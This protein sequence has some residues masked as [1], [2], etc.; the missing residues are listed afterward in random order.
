[1]A[2]RVD[3]D[4]AVHKLRVGGLAAFP[5]E[6]L[7]SLSCRPDDLAAVRALRT[8]K[9]RPDD[10]PLALGF[11][12]WRDAWAYAHWTPGAR[13]LAEAFLPGPLSLVLRAADDDTDHLAPGLG[14]LSVRIPDHPTAQAVLRGI[15]PIVM[16]S[17]NR[18]GEADA[19]SADDVD[20]QLAGVPD[21]AIVDE[22]P[23]VGGLGSTVVDC[24]GDGPRI[25]REGV[26]SQMEV[27]AAWPQ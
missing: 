2:T 9:G 10:V 19:R 14:T 11:A 20:A 27:E 7:W 4:E 13:A 16:T 12:S 5:T 1:M 8:A 21:L 24:T 23:P 17:A 18:H 3:V 22:G 15:A 26:I 25:L 6:T